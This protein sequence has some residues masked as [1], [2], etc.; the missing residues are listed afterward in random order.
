MKFKD[1]PYTRPDMEKVKKIFLPFLDRT[2]Y[3]GCR[4]KY[5]VF[6]EQII[7]K[8]DIEYYSNNETLREKYENG[9]LI[10]N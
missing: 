6:I 3:V 10:E 7:L 9:K 1:M 4:N 8:G 2:V 5:L